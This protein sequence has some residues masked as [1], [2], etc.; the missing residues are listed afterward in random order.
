MLAPVS[1]PPVPGTH[2]IDTGLRYETFYRGL[3]DQRDI[4]YDPPLESYGQ[5][6][7]W[8]EDEGFYLE[9]PPCFSFGRRDFPM[10]PAR[11]QVVN[12]D[13]DRLYGIHYDTDTA[14]TFR[15]NGRKYGW[16]RCWFHMCNGTGCLES[17]YFLADFQRG[18][19]YALALSAVP[20]PTDYFGD[21]NRDG[22]LDLLIP[23]FM[24]HVG[25]QLPRSDT[26]EYLTLT[27]YTFGKSG[28]MEA[29][30][31]D[32]RD[33]QQV[34]SVRMRDFDAYDFRSICSYGSFWL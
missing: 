31:E 22:A 11:M 14:F 30:R 1:T 2:L 26:T 27:P 24:Y 19:L 7:G 33:C 29:I 18:R 13:G 10:T 23:D 9:D 8:S 3:I 20:G 28:R 12:E 15:F 32:G 25:G 16:A 34:I 4:V 21:V 5:C 6:G 17:F